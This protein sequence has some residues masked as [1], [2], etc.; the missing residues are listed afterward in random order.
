ML[1][2]AACRA[3]HRTP[4][5]GDPDGSLANAFRVAT[6]TRAPHK[7]RDFLLGAE[8]PQL[9]ESAFLFL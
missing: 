6:A 2:W 1:L 5:L 9:S 4:E 3:T 7:R 8:S